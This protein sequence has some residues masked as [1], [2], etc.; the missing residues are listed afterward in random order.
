MK[1]VAGQSTPDADRAVAVMD[2]VR[3]VCD[4][5]AGLPG[6]TCVPYTRDFLTWE[7]FKIIKQDSPQRF[8]V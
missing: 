4:S 7:T 2:G 8:R 3:A 1:M 6:G 5:Q